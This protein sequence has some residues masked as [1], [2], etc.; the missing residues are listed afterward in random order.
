MGEAGADGRGATR[1]GSVSSDLFA[2]PR[3]RWWRQ[4][5]RRFFTGL[6]RRRFSLDEQ[7]AITDL[8]MIAGTISDSPSIFVPLMTTPLY[9]RDRARGTGR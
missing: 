7:R 9:S 6:D 4:R 5:L 2:R 1:I 8:E 3:R